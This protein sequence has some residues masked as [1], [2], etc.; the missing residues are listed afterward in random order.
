MN[1]NPELTPPD[2]LRDKKEYFNTK[3]YVGFDHDFL[4]LKTRIHPIFVLPQQ[5]AS[6]KISRS[7][8]ILLLA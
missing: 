1:N 7:P 3:S 4:F 2:E 5:V 8:L 6:T